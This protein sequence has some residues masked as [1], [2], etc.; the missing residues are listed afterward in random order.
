MNRTPSTDSCIHVCNELL[1]GEI[2]ACETY[3]Q[4]I[5]KFRGDPGTTA[6]ERIRDEHRDS[7]RK[8]RANVEKMGGR[9]STD[10]GAW[11]VFAK[12]VEGTAKLFGD[13]SAVAA[14][15]QGEEHGIDEYTSALENPDVLDDCKTLI[16]TQLLPRLRTHVQELNAL[17]A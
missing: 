13:A 10:S 14:L 16:S 5:E 2:S 8:L 1:R 7:V 15:R 3:E 17:P 11:G 4:A 12:T 6:L 9:P